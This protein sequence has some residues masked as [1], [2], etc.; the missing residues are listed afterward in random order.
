M[1][2]KLPLLRGRKLIKALVRMGFVV[3]RQKGSHVILRLG[4]KTVVI[5]NTSETI[6]KGTLKSILKQT[7]LSIEEILKYYLLLK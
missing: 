6:P 1:L 3:R 7:Q 2:K 5:K 4:D